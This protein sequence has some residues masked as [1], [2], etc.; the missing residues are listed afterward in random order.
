LCEEYAEDDCWIINMMEYAHRGEM[1]VEFTAAA[2]RISVS[3]EDILGLLPRRRH[4]ADEKLRGH[5]D[6][7]G[8]ERDDCTSTYATM[9]CVVTGPRREAVSM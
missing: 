9:C 2:H 8:T 3:G 4:E 6:L 7:P 5:E 1:G